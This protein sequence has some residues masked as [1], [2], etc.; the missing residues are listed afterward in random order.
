M[1][2][3]NPEIKFDKKTW[4]DYIIK[5]NDRE[6]NKRRQSGFT[7]WALLGTLAY[8]LF[9]IL[10]SSP[11]IFLNNKTIVTFVVFL[12]LISNLVIIILNCLEKYLL[13][14][15][16]KQSPR[17][18]ITDLSKKRS[19]LMNLSYNLFHLSSLFLN[20]Y[21]YLNRN[22]LNL[23]G[24]PFLFFSILYSLNFI[25]FFIYFLRRLGRGKFVQPED[26]SLIDI[27]L[28][29]NQQY[30]LPKI[31]TIIMNAILNFSFICIYMATII[32]VKQ[33]I[34][35]INNIEFL[36]LAIES[37]AIFFIITILCFQ[38]FSMIKNLWLEGF[39]RDIITKDID[40]ETIK[41]L[42][43]QEFLGTD[44][45]D[46]LNNVNKEIDSAKQ[47]Y[48]KAFD[49]FNRNYCELDI[50]YLINITDIKEALEI[51]DADFILNAQQQYSKDMKDMKDALEI[52]EINSGY[53]DK[54]IQAKEQYILALQSATHKI[55]DFVKQGNIQ[56][57]ENDI[58]SIISSNIYDI[59][60]NV[61][62]DMDRVMKCK[63][64]EQETLN[65]LKQKTSQ[66]EGNLENLNIKI[67]SIKES[68]TGDSKLI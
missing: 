32:D 1:Q 6:I 45:R 61:E 47:T 20:I 12:T 46:W 40:T 62:A 9:N 21:V 55:R 44:T 63:I 59:I 66:L 51:S 31:I 42:F 15:K 49:E 24:A 53:I 67:S 34:G 5:L 41:S 25:A 18:L 33:K 17:K 11:K 3:N 52:M 29:K 65:T 60:Y 22:I 54:L 16:V 57:S 27:L 37:V 56:P 2:I 23:I 19:S 10:D 48:K 68:I 7:V 30:N 43:I 28:N 35:Y 13:F 36:K 14:F 38:L 58:I 39:E 4:L 64:D 50:D 26:T 8:V